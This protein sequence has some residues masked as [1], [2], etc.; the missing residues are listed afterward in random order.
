M[1]VSWVGLT[2]PA[3]VKQ[4]KDVIAK[5]LEM[6]QNDC[7]AQLV[8]LENLEHEILMKE[9]I[10]LTIDPN[11][12]VP[13]AGPSA[14]NPGP[15]PIAAEPFGP[16][17]VG[18]ATPSAP[19]K[20]SPPKAVPPPFFPA[21]VLPA[22][23]GTV[24]KIPRAA[25]RQ[26]AES[27]E[28]SSSEDS[29]ESE[30]DEL[31]GEEEAEVGSAASTEAGGDEEPH[32]FGDRNA[33]QLAMEGFYHD[34]GLSTDHLKALWVLPVGTY[35]G[36]GSSGTTV[37]PSS[38]VREAQMAP[39][40]EGPCSACVRGGRICVAR[41]WMTCVGCYVHKV[42]CSH[43]AEHVAMA[44][45]I[46]IAVPSF[47]GLSPPVGH[48]VAF[49]DKQK[50]VYKE[51]GLARTPID[52]A[53]RMQAG[54]NAINHAHW[55]RRLGEPFPYPVAQAAVPP[56]SLKKRAASGEFGSSV[57]RRRVSGLAEVEREGSPLAKKSAPAAMLVAGPV[58]PVAR[59]RKGKEKETGKETPASRR[60]AYHEHLAVLVRY[61][62]NSNFE[63][64]K[65]A[66]EYMDRVG[67]GVDIIFAEDI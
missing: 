25:A 40:V 39:P 11:V 43:T 57:K 37:G 26:V 17:A 29:D 24:I 15:L 48:D 60:A 41:H 35:G 53:R 49:F 16:P 14:Q 22:R 21:T 20:K 63:K 64:V 10:K 55:L 45:K 42:K 36:R 32:V 4:R 3:V 59:G 13:V 27:E 58:T 54:D 52:I 31:A 6:Q 1:V 8:E 38:Y 33:V 56:S 61:G 34:Y 67:G 28:D 19:T 12:L 65:E 9:A 7:R 46:K 66:A 23:G 5:H 62:L 2:G 30:E 44:E 47:R 18:P 50:A 51:L